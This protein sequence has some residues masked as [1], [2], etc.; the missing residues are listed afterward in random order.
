[1]VRYDLPQAVFAALSS[2]LAS[3]LFY[4]YW[5]ANYYLLTGTPVNGDKTGSMRASLTTSSL[6]ML[7]GAFLVQNRDT[8]AQPITGNAVAKQLSAQVKGEIKD[9][10][11]AFNNKVNYHESQSYFNQSKSFVRIHIK[12][13][14]MGY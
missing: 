14:Q 2:V 5:F 6:D 1:M 4:Q 3:G 11:L 10:P 9:G 8:Q 13:K 7:V 12:T